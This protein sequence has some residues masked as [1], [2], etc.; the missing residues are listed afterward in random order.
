[1]TPAEFDL[2]LESI[3]RLSDTHESQT[4]LLE[5]LSRRLMSILEPVEDV[6]RDWHWGLEEPHLGEEDHLQSMFVLR[7]KVKVVDSVI[8][9]ADDIYPSLVDIAHGAVTCIDDAVLITSVVSSQVSLKDSDIKDRVFM[10]V[11]SSGSARLEDV[12]RAWATLFQEAPAAPVEFIPQWVRD[13]VQF[14]AIVDSPTTRDTV[15][16]LACP[17]G[18]TTSMPSAQDILTLAG[19]LSVWHSEGPPHQPLGPEPAP[20]GQPDLTSNRELGVPKAF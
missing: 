8:Q 10:I 6:S 18:W 4:T 9:K 17:N 16:H 20:T 13:S 7:E 15:L 1:M 14:M 12:K 11:R 3:V 2:Y 19:G 5:Q